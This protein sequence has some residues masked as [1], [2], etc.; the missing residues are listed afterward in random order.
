M[1]VLEGGIKCVLLMFEMLY[2]QILS[3]LLTPSKFYAKKK[4]VSRTK[5]LRE[6]VIIFHTVLYL[7][8]L[9]VSFCVKQNKVKGDLKLD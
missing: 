2:T 8:L 6:K 4:K 1:K 5:K 3:L 7:N 9:F